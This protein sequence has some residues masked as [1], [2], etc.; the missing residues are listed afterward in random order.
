MKERSNI[1]LSLYRAACPVRGMVHFPE[2]LDGKQSGASLLPG[3]LA[4][5]ADFQ[6]RDGGLT[7]ANRGKRSAIEHLVPCHVNLKA[8]KRRMG[9]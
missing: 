2:A 8:E 1:P 7:D 5:H 4:S 9:E 6:L 3:V